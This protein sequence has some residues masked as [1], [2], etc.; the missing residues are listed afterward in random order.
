MLP[1]FLQRNLGFELRMLF[2][3]RKWLSRSAALACG[4]AAALAVAPALS[5]ALTTH[6]LADTGRIELGSHHHGHDHSHAG[7]GAAG[8][9]SHHDDGG[10]PAKSAQ[11]DKAGVACCGL[12]LNSAYVMH[13]LIELPARSVLAE[14]VFAPVPAPDGAVPDPLHRPPRPLLSA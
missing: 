12:S 5:V 4:L 1:E 8:D 2:R 6:A 9:A 10:R 14:R 3:L 13:F 7:A 11:H